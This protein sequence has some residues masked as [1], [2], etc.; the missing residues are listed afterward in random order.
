M[1]TNDLKNFI[2]VNRE[3]FEIYDYPQEDW[4]SISDKLDQ[5]EKRA[6]S[7]VIPLKYVWRSAAV[8]LLLT[9]AAFYMSW[10]NWNNQA[11]EVM[12]SSELQEAEYYYGELIATKVAHISQLD[13]NAE[14]VVFRNMETM[15][16]AFN[17]L[18]SDLKDNAD[19]EEVIHA[20]ID[21]YKIKLE[22]LEQIIE[23]LEDRKEL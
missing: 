21:N 2:D 1:E 22:I 9:G 4:P 11:Q 8:F 19:N 20:M 13:H 12:M 16:Q 18:K 3:S 23:Q 17:E 7:V 14:Q 6:K 15:D 10:V 5:S